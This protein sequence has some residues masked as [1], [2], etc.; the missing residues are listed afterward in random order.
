M[1]TE[2]AIQTIYGSTRHNNG[3]LCQYSN[4][5]N[6]LTINDNFGYQR[7]TVDHLGRVIDT[8]GNQT[9][10][11]LINGKIIDSL[12]STLGYVN[13]FD[14][15]NNN[16]G[17]GSGYNVSNFNYRNEIPRDPILPTLYSRNDYMEEPYQVRGYGSSSRC[18]SYGQ[19]NGHS[20][21][22]QNRWK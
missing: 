3:P 22:Y 7:G 12:G 18:E 11:N 5:H 1:L 6:N 19:T 16:L 14:R 17:Q 10:F 2:Y 9:G 4:L 8:M 21:W 20:L 13:N 15:I